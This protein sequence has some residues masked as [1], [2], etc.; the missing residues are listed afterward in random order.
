MLVDQAN[1]LDGSCLD[2]DKAKASQGVAAE[3]HVVK[4]AAR[5]GGPGAIMDH[6]RHNQ[7]VLEC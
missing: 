1:L 6:R 5:V 7:S 3:M 4:G 2:K